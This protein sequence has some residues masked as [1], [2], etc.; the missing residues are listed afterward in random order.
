VCKNNKITAVNIDAIFHE[1][2]SKLL[3][4][5]FFM[6]DAHSR[7]AAAAAAAVKLHHDHLQTV[8]ATVW[9]LS[10][11]SYSSTSGWDEA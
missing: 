8:I 10:M 6:L 11:A 1:L 5:M 3:V 9:Q 7:P 2:S 4:V